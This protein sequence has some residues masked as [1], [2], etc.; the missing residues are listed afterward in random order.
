MTRLGVRYIAVLRNREPTAVEPPG[1]QW[2]DGDLYHQVGTA[3]RAHERYTSPSA[4][5]VRT[6]VADLDALPNA[7]TQDA[8]SA[9]DATPA[10][11]DE[12]AQHHERQWLAH[13]TELLRVRPDANPDDAVAGEL[14]RLRGECERMRC[15]VNAAILVTVDDRYACRGEVDGCYF[16][17]Y[18][19]GYFHGERCR[20]G[21]SE[22]LLCESVDAYRSAAPVSPQRAPTLTLAESEALAEARAWLDRAD[23]ALT[24]N[25]AAIR[26]IDKLMKARST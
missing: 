22:R 25:R 2:T 21:M 24:W 15:V 23:G 6:L 11:V 12:Y 14:V 16:N 9:G 7:D 13:Y 10:Q 17:Q 20:Q 18:T 26:A 8:I 19:G 5:H 4:E 3:V 1:H